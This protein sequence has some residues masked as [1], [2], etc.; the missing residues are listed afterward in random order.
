[1]IFMIKV[2]LMDLGGVYFTEGKKIAIERISKK[3]SVNPEKLRKS[4]SK[5]ISR[6]WRKGK[7]N[8]KYFVKILARKL[9]VE[10]KKAKE[11]IRIWHDS[12]TPRNGMN[13]I[14]KKLRK[15]YK[16]VVLSG[17]TKERIRYIDNK[18]NFQKEFDKCLYS[19][20]FGI[21]KPESRIF[22][23]SIKKMKVKPKE[24]VMIDDSDK[25][26]RNVKKAGGLA[27]RF[28][29]PKKLQSDLRSI[30]VIV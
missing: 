24:C 11:M 13:R 16:V 23:A 2:I 6:E 10:E 20:T 19:F 29:N 22:K 18:Y 15:N 28:R 7:I 9:N 4:L 8:E 26:L 17:N 21:N 27:I 25:F 5:D 14:V 3:F 1:M 12:Y 30:G